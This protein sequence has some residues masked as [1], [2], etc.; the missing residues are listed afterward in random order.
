MVLKVFTHAGQRVQ[1]RDAGDG[2]AYR[3]RLSAQGLAL[4]RRILPPMS[5]TEQEAIDAALLDVEIGDSQSWDIATVL[6]Q[7]AGHANDGPRRIDIGQPHHPPLPDRRPPP[8]G[9]PPRGGIPRP[10]R[11]HRH[12]AAHR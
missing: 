12:R 6:Q 10:P 1:R 5:Q 8:C 11:P 3:L 7:R 9:A 4:Y 2:R